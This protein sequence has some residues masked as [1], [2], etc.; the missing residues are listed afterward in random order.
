MTRKNATSTRGKP[1]AKGNPGRPKGARN[2]T[3]QAVEAL[4]DGEAEELTRLAI[5]RAKAGDMVALK[6]CMERIC[7]PRKDTPVTL[8]LPAIDGAADLP[9]VL[10]RVLDHVAAG[11]ITPSEAK[12][13]AELID[14]AR[15]AMESGE[16]AERVAQLEARHG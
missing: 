13:M 8:S 5:E 7:P 1:F 12:T 14:T 6:L 16:L 2:K 9:G 3:T 11:S 4:L 15:R 10:I